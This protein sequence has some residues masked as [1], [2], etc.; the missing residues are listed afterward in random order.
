MENVPRSETS[1]HR[2]SGLSLLDVHPSHDWT[3]RHALAAVPCSDFRLDCLR[4]RHA[5]GHPRGQVPSMR[6]AVL[7][8]GGGV[9]AND[10]RMPPLWTGKVRRSE[11]R[12]TVRQ[13][14]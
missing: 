9:L 12:T 6:S 4:S 5:D 10:E 7:R 1:W 2:F 3:A 13:P 11:F 14:W 8:Q